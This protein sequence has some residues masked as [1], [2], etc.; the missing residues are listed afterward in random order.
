MPSP[1]QFVK[2]YGNTCGIGLGSAFGSGVKNVSI[3][4][5]F[6]NLGSFFASVGVGSRGFNGYVVQGGTQAT[7][8][9]TFS[10]LANNDTVTVNGVVFTAKTSGAT[11][12]NQFNLGANDTAAAVNFAA[13]I[14]SS[15]APAK[16][17]G[18]VSAS[19]AAAVTTITFLETGAVG[20]LGT[21]AISAHG[22]VSAANLANGTDGTITPLAKGL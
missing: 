10:S 22:S 14:N 2:T 5:A 4:N 17:L 9:V 1:T 6:R 21:L 7:G 3:A 15:S 12:S 13:A 18:V 16:I 8:T 20:N 19:P 11:G